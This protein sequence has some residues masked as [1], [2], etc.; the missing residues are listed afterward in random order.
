MSLNIPAASF[1]LIV[2]LI[3]KRNVKKIYFLK[4]WILS[5][6]E[7]KNIDLVDRGAVRQNVIASG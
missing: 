2:S 4:N 7:Q 5:I 6:A 1:V 3:G